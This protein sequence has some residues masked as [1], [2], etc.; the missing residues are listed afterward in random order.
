MSQIPS[1]QNSSEEAVVV[2]VPTVQGSAEQLLPA[3][4]A[5]LNLSEGIMKALESSG[6]TTPT[7]IQARTIPLLLQGRDV[8]GQAQTGTGKTAAFAIP[9]LE[10]IDISK[11]YPQ[12]LVLTPTREL[13]IQV[14]EAF[15]RYAAG[16]PGLRAVAIYGGQDYQV[17]FR[18]LDRG[19]HVIVGTPGRV[20]DHMRRG[21]LKLDGLRGLILD[22]ADEMLN[23]GFAEDVEWVLTQSP[24]DRQIA[25]FSA[26]MPDQIRRIAQQHL[27]EPVQ[28]TIRQ[29]TA[30]ADTIRQ[31][32]VIA[33]PHQK[34]AAL[35]RILEAEPIDGVIVFVKMKSTTEPLADFLNSCGYRAG[36]LSGDVAQKQRERI[37]ANLKAGKLDVVVA[38]DVAA[39]GLDVQRVSHVINYDLPFDDEA[40]VHR[41]GRTGR[42]GR[43]GE[44][45]LFVHPRERHLLKR[46]ERATRQPIEPMDLPSNEAINE[47]R[48]SKYYEK[49][50]AALAHP[51]LDRFAAIVEKYRAERDLPIEKIAAALAVLGNGDTPLLLTDNLKQHDFADSRSDSRNDGPRSRDGRSIEG[52][53]R[54]RSGPRTDEGMET[55]RI[56]VGR[57]NQV[58]PGNIVGAIINET[59]LEMSHIGR[60]EIFDDFSTVDLPE[61]MPKEIFNALKKVWVMGRK[62]NITRVEAPR[63]PEGGRR[64]DRDRVVNKPRRDKFVAKP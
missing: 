25:L 2:A 40:Y 50:T 15:E 58:N 48:V 16:M 28:I 13:A 34:E 14:A 3:T 43:S 26:T 4:F 61:G 33:A 39:R 44:A 36:A 59:G 41:I 56:E 18:Q 42:A 63:F 7:P 35:G 10:R 38:T 46:L 49:I 60:I 45:I 17:Q 11:K 31:R 5:E 1:V 6:Y 12:V 37:V 21:S 64:F 54:R 29:K 55:F 8:L 47:Q 22:E 27:R 53:E 52:G 20:M 30:T 57:V 62:L 9:M 51:D 23:M 32:F 24:A 19:V